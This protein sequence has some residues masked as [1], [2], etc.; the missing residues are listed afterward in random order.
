MT[1]HHHGSAHQ[2]GPARRTWRVPTP[3]EIYAWSSV[4]VAGPRQTLRARRRARPGRAPGGP[5][6]LVSGP[7]YLSGAGL[8]RR[9]RRRRGRGRGRGCVTSTLMRRHQLWLGCVVCC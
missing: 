4:A 2:N 8:I 5:P 6:G 1:P 9:R 7:A 3:T